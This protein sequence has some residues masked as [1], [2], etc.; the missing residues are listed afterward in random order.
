MPNLPFG[1]AVV[2]LQSP[3]PAAAVVNNEYDAAAS[4]NLWKTALMRSLAPLTFAAATVGLK[5]SI[6]FCEDGLRLCFIGYASGGQALGEFAATTMAVIIEQS[7]A[8]QCD[9]GA[10]RSFQVSVSR[11]NSMGATTTTAGLRDKKQMAAAIM[12]ATPASAKE[13][14]KALF[15]S[16]F[17]S[18]IV[19]GGNLKR[20][21]A[22]ELALAIDASIYAN[23]PEMSRHSVS[24]E[25]A[26]VII[27]SL[28]YRPV[29]QP[30][31]AQD[32]CLVSGIAGLL[33][34]CGQAQ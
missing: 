27:D 15:S 11:S 29:W 4:A 20:D 13:E 21:Q 9:A 17:G 12:A 34:T 30:A 5:Y 31:A 28:L 1:V 18:K 24:I 2:L 14:A 3:R 32:A 26:D 8:F 7:A 6:D 22:S 19:I 25:Q 10:W 16:V 33:S 23:L